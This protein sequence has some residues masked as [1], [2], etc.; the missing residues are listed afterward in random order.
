MGQHLLIGMAAPLLLV[1]A[2]PLTLT[3]RVMTCGPHRRL[4]RASRSRAVATLVFPPVAALLDSAGLWLLYRTGL[5]AATH[6][7]AW[8]HGL[9]HFHVLIGGVLFTFAVCQLDPLRHPAGLAVRA[10]T[11]ILAGTAHAVLAKTLYYDPPPGTAFTTTDLAHAAK[12]M[13]YGGDLIEITLAAVLAAQWYAA[14]GRE[15]TRAR[16]RTTAATTGD[17]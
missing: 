3:L 17:R 14:S 1:M 6:D 11:L 5:F 8:L 15:L 9:V 10:G 4:L 13:Y 2:R 12:L 16:R 7:A